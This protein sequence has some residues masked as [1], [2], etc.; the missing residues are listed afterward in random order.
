MVLHSY[1][2]QRAPNVFDTMTTMSSSRILTVLGFLFLLAVLLSTH[3]E[4]R[5][6]ES[7]PTKPRHSVIAHVGTK[8]IT[9]REVERAVA[10]PL[11]QNPLPL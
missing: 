3:W 2:T 6:H 8:S 1:L 9:L 4:F 11:R 5:G 7:K 10:L